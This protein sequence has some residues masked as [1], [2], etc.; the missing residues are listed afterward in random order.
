MFNVKFRKI[1]V[2]SALLGLLLTMQTVN[3]AVNTSLTYSACSLGVYPYNPSGQVASPYDTKWFNLMEG[4]NNPACY[5]HIEYP[6]QYKPQPP[7]YNDNQLKNEPGIDNIK[8]P[9]AVHT[10]IYHNAD[11]EDDFYY[12]GYMDSMQIIL[13]QDALTNTDLNQIVCLTPDQNN[14]IYETPGCV[15]KS[16]INIWGGTKITFDKNTGVVTWKFANDSKG[17]PHFW[18][19]NPGLPTVHGFYGTGVKMT[20][21]SSLGNQAKTVWSATTTSRAL[22]RHLAIKKSTVS[23]QDVLNNVPPLCANDGIPNS[24]PNYDGQWCTTPASNVA[25]VEQTHVLVKD[26]WDPSSKGKEYYWFRIGV[27]GTVWK[28]PAPVVQ[29]I[30]CTGLTITPSSWVAGKPVTFNV[31]PTFTP[32]GKSVDLDYTWNAQESKGNPLSPANANLNGNNLLQNN[33]L[34]NNFLALAGSPNPAQIPGKA[35]ANL[36]PANALVQ[37]NTP[38]LNNVVDPNQLLLDPFG[39]FADSATSKDF[40]RPYTDVD[41]FSQALGYPVD[42]TDTYYTGSTGAL[43]TLITIDAI[44]SAYN[45]QPIDLSKCKASLVIPALPIPPPKQPVITCKNITVDFTPTPFNPAGKTNFTATVNLQDQNGKAV[46]YTGKIDFNALENGKAKGLFDAGNNLKGVPVDAP[47]V[48]GTSKVSYTSGGATTNVTIMPTDAK[49][50][51]PSCTAVIK[52]QAKP[53]PVCHSL[54]IYGNGKQYPDSLSSADLQNYPLKDLYL[55]VD[56]DAGLNLNY[57]WAGAVNSVKAG[58]FTAIDAL[59]KKVLGPANP[60]TITHDNDKTTFTGVSQTD[61]TSI[62]VFGYDKNDGFKVNQCADTIQISPPG[63]PAPNVCTALN[64]AVNGTP[65][66]QFNNNFVDGQSYTLST[67]PT[68]QIAPN[69]TQVQWN[70]SGSGYLQAVPGAPQEC[71]AAAPTV[72]SQQPNISV[73]FAAPATCKYTYA[74][75]AGGTIT[76]IVA[77]SDQNISVGDVCKA[78]FTVPQAPPQGV[79]QSMTALTPVGNNKY[80][81]TVT[82]PEYGSQIRW[83]PT[84]SVDVDA[85]NLCATVRPNNTFPLTLKASIP[86]QS[87][88]LQQ[89]VITAPPVPPTPPIPPTITKDIMSF[90]DPLNNGGP[91]KTVTVSPLD[92]APLGTNIVHYRLIFT[93]NSPNTNAVLHDRIE[94]NGNGPGFNATLL[95]G[96]DP[97]TNGGHIAYNGNMIVVENGSTIPMCD[98]KNITADCYNGDI[99]S[100][101]GLSLTK[102]SNPVTITYDGVIDINSSKIND[103]SCQNG[104]VC[105]EKYVNTTQITSASVDNFMFPPQLTPTPNNT[106]TVQI[107]CQYILSRAS[108]DIYLETDMNLGININQCSPYKSTTGII[109]I[110]TVTKP[111]IPKTGAGQTVTIKHEVCQQN[112]ADQNQNNN[113]E[114]LKLYDQSGKLSSQVCEIKLNTTPGQS[115]DKVV[116]TNSIAENIKRIAR[117][118]PNLDGGNN[119]VG[120]AGAPITSVSG[121]FNQVFSIDGVYHRAK[122]DLYLGQSGATPFTQD[123]DGAKTFIVENHDLYITNNITIGG[124]QTYCS[125]RDTAALAFVVLNGNVYIS[126][127]VTEIDAVIFVQGD[128]KDKGQLISGSKKGAAERSKV[129][130]TVKGSVYGDIQPLLKMRVFSG[131]PAL[132]QGSVVLRTDERIFINTPPGLQDLVDVKSEITA[133]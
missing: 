55:V 60:L 74:A 22:I 13:E 6:N 33:L 76:A 62:T 127:N 15:T 91:K 37:Q 92:H 28:T 121:A 66:A 36:A 108:G 65:V 123:G 40:G 114:L 12:M 47:T 94:G 99:G 95:P 93:P 112:V 129:Q 56:K 39:F 31:K 118:E 67:S 71:A 84:A 90:N 54:Q 69:P 97:N 98:G 86:G 124:C 101:V 63:K 61:N 35:N 70:K 132:N 14:K 45:L 57:D 83:E 87:N 107:F 79:C 88:C 78:S 43:P 20:V 50:Q 100:T 1:G 44:S 128:T 102:V 52:P 119:N 82:P 16:D 133:R 41:N 110:P 103:Q 59:S 64:L 58:Q 126:P 48:N 75:A 77:E 32:A 89:L 17:R 81:V 5:S 51:V 30:A 21:K 8:V 106:A 2:I 117:W 49:Y 116:I 53:L 10:H 9:Q 25:G 125:P 122:G 29:P 73:T 104:N 4:T 113:S 96:T 130:L 120:I 11:L 105:E 23:K 24:V 46:T 80:C 85:N 42:D 19:T 38:V 34:S 111:I 115:W 109:I 3:A 7:V 68:N 26:Q 131:D 72:A 27:V 18:G